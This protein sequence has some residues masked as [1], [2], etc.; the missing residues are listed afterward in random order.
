MCDAEINSQILYLIFTVCAYWYL[1]LLCA[2]GNAQGQGT[3]RITDPLLSFDALGLSV[4]LSHA[5][6]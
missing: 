2:D 4:A 6:T 5:D 1:S 3:D